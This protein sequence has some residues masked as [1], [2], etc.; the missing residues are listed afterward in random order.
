MERDEW[1]NLGLS[2]VSGKDGKNPSK[3]EPSQ[4]S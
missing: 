4:N 2:N 3:E 1:K